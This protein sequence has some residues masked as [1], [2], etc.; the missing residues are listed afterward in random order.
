MIRTQVQLTEEQARR[1]RSIARQ[2]G[3]SLAEVIRQCVN[4]ALSK[5]EPERAQLYARAAQLVGRFE[6]LEKASDL[7]TEHDRYLDDSFR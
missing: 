7:A 5:R 1:L 3:I 4:E 6:D 2:E